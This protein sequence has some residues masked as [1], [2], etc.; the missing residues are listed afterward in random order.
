MPAITTSAERTGAAPTP[1][2]HAALR[3]EARLR[4]EHSGQY[5]G[6]VPGQWEAAA[7]LADRVLASRILRGRD[8]LHPGRIL[9]DA[10][11]EFRGGDTRAS[12]GPPARPRRED[13]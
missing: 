6:L 11:F 13:R 5:P 9:A 4:P 12:S 3:R 10:H 2:R 1:L 7:T 8:L